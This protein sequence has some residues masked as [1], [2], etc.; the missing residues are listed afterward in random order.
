[1]CG[2]VVMPRLACPFSSGAVFVVVAGVLCAAAAAGRYVALCRR[3]A[4][5]TCVLIVFSRGRKQGLRERS[6]PLLP[7]CSPLLPS[8][9]AL[10]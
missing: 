8:P 4:G 10:I 9:P 6:S 1:M 7:L 2:A 3:P 5:M